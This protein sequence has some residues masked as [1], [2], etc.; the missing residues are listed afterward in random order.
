MNEFEGFNVVHVLEY[1]IDL[2]EYI[3]FEILKNQ[4]S[5]VR[6]FAQAQLQ[7]LAAL[8]RFPEDI[9]IRLVTDFTKRILA[10]P[11][12]PRLEPLKSTHRRGRP[13]GSTK[14]DPS[15]FEFVEQAIKADI[16]EKKRKA[17][18]ENVAEKS[19]KKRKVSIDELI[20]TYWIKTN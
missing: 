16:R 4:T 1:I 15:K 10:M 8:E 6:T 19:T 12:E 3:I 17:R 20:E 7:N 13:S 18:E 14:L 11:D 2:T 9:K 5:T